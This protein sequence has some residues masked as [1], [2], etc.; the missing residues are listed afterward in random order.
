MSEN[1]WNLTLLTERLILRPQQSNDY[2]AWYA[3][4]AGRLSKQHPYDAGIV[5]LEGCDLQWSSE[6]CQRHQQ[7]ALTD[8]VYVFGVLLRE[9]NEHLGNIDLSTIRRADNQWA[10]LGYSIHN[11]HQHQG[12]GKEAVRSALI[13]GFEKLNYHRI[14][15]AINLDNEPS[16]ALVKSVGNLEANDFNRVSR[17]LK[18]DIKFSKE[19]RLSKN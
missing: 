11:Q 9:T 19:I 12:F 18:T 4:F 17:S 3:S 1:S 15:A 16:I 10:N 7:L 5:D 2:E 6:L 14:E 8:R 13:A